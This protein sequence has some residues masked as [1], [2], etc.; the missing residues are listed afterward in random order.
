MNVPTCLNNLKTKVDDLDVCKSKTALVD[1]K[2]LNDLI[3]NEVI[4]NTKLKTLK[5]KV[6][7][8]EN[9]IPDGTALIHVNQ[10]NADKQNLEKKIGDI[11]KKL[12]D[13]IG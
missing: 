1:L 10:Y 13:T 5:R 2:N 11:D 4:K 7:N 12:P 3:D 6:N 9:K 8:L